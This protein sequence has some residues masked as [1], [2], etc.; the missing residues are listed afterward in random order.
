MAQN[1]LS[2]VRE[3]LVRLDEE[4]SYIESNLQTL[5]AQRDELTA[6]ATTT[7]EQ[8]GGFRGNEHRLAHQLKNEITQGEANLAV[9]LQS[10]TDDYPNIK[11]M[12]QQIEAK[13][14]ERDKLQTEE[15]AAAARVQRRA[16]GGLKSP[17]SGKTDRSSTAISKTS[18][19]NCATKRVTG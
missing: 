19:F 11:Q 17:D 14:Q 3:A 1:S 6:M 9:A 15:D 12:K 18:I 2:A 8:G 10:Y 13:K 7:I 5:K 16:R 4:K